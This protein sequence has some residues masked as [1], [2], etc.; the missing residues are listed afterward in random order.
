MNLAVACAFMPHLPCEITA[1]PHLRVRHETLD[2]ARLA[3]FASLLALIYT[4]LNPLTFEAGRCTAWTNAQIAAGAFPVGVVSEE[5]RVVIPRADE[6]RQPAFGVL[7]DFFEVLL[8][9]PLLEGF[10]ERIHSGVARVGRCH[11]VNDGDTTQAQIGFDVSRFDA[12][13]SQTV[14]L[15]E[16]HAEGILKAGFFA[17]VAVIDVSET[18]AQVREQLLQRIAFFGVGRQ[19]R[20]IDVEL[21]QHEVVMLAVFAGDINLLGDAAILFIPTRIAAVDDDMRA[22]WQWAILPDEVKVAVVSHLMLNS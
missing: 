9:L 2:D 1:L 21:I 16:D 3:G 13:T 5:F 19:L 6:L 4:D 7:R 20:L 11:Q 18:A 10:D 14:G 8:I 17:F 12:V 15:S 22:G